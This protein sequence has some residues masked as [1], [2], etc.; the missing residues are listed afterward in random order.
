MQ[1]E[2]RYPFYNFYS[3]PISTNIAAIELFIVYDGTQETFSL[4]SGWHANVT[5]PPP[6]PPSSWL[7][8]QFSARSKSSKAFLCITICA[9]PLSLNSS[10]ILLCSA[11]SSLY[12]LTRSQCTV[13]MYRESSYQCSQCAFEQP[14]LLP[15]KIA[16]LSNV[17]PCHASS[18]MA[19]MITCWVI[20]IPRVIL[21]ARCRVRK[22]VGDLLA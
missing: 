8:P 3:A 16:V 17:S 2:D 14:V 20:S 21:L 4:C 7:F 12:L 5:S 15:R 18:G 1:N 22:G 13:C 19:A 10:S 9:F 11:K 6:T